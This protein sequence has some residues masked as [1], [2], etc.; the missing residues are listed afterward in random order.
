M[1]AKLRPIIGL[2]LVAILISACFIPQV[3][4]FLSLPDYQRL[5]VGETST[6][7]INLPSSLDSK[8]E[9]KVMGPSRSVFA[10]PED[11]PVMITRNGTNYQIVALKPGEADVKLKLMGYIPLKSIKIESIPPRRVV[12]GGHSIGVMLQSRGIMVVGFAPVLD[13]DGTKRY[14]ARDQGIQIGD[15]IF[16]VNGKSITTET[17][18]ARL[19]DQEKDNELVVSI[20]RRDKEINLP[21]KSVYC[22]ETERYRIGLYVRDGVVGVGTLTFWDPDSSQYAALGH[23]IVDAD[24][25]QGIDVLKGKIVS[26]SIQ[27]IKPARPGFPGEKIGIFND[28]GNINGNIIKNSFFGIYGKT[29]SAISNPLSRYVMEVGYSHQVKKGRAQ[30]YTVVNGDAIEA[31][32]IEIEK[33]YPQRQSGKGMVI[34]V[35]DPR[36]LSLTGGI[37]QGMSGSPIIQNNRIIGAVTHVFLNDPQRGYGI[38]MDNMLPELPGSQTARNKV[39]T[40][41]LKVKYPKYG[42]QGNTNIISGLKT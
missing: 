35:T 42:H 15:L 23:I 16:K 39:S 36:L 1:R 11:P 18:L 21:V 34:R 12:A 31:F 37:V 29:S 9:M 26:A 38:F 20:K 40:F 25:K 2:I 28:K 33:V 14:P 7:N 6:I 4:T 17:D 30:I 27:T 5:V 19:I 10:S 8:I 41:A 3:N 22:S 24:T 13:T 32:D